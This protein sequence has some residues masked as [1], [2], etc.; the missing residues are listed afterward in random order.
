MKSSVP[1]AGFTPNSVPQ[2]LGGSLVQDEKEDA[3][4]KVSHD[5]KPTA[6]AGHPGD[7]QDE[8]NDLQHG[9]PVPF[10]GAVLLPVL[11]KGSANG[12]KSAYHRK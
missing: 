12:D 8:R 10:Q 4:P 6:L 1:G 5:R 2:S 9:E 7:N 11:N 3:E